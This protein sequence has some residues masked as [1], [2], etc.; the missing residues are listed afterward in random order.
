MAMANRAIY[1][2]DSIEGAMSD[3]M[4]IAI[5][6]VASAV[7][8]LSA[9][10]AYHQYRKTR[11]IAEAQL[12]TRTLDQYFSQEMVDARVLT[13]GAVG[14]ALQDW[15]PEEYVATERVMKSFGELGFLLKNKHITSKEFLVWWGPTIVAV[16][17]IGKP[18]I[19]YRRSTEGVG[20]HFIYFEWVARQAYLLSGKRTPWFSRAKWERI[21][22]RSADIETATQ[23]VLKVGQKRPHAP[24]V[25][26]KGKKIPALIQTFLRNW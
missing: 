4:Q 3:A 8:T 13:Y 19:E 5:S 6:M 2:A 10:I 16:Y 15:T 23:D 9:L 7:A 21:K 18:L 26:G 17:Q 1:F 12:I 22:K 25:P 20:S 14:K 11:S 24:A